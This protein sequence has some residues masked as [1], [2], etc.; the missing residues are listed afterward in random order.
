MAAGH[1]RRSPPEDV[2]PPAVRAEGRQQGAL[3]TDGLLRRVARGD[4]AAFARVCDEVSGAV[5]GLV[6]L[7]VAD[8]A[9]AEQVASDV[10]IEVWRSAPRFDPAENS[11]LSWIMTMARRRAISQAAAS[12]P[13]AGSEPGAA[14]GAAERAAGSL[15]AHRG[16]AVLPAQQ[17]TAVSLAC[18]GYTGRQVAELAGVPAA[19]AAVWLRDG[20]LGLSSCPDYPAAN[21]TENR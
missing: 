19:T 14:A 3:S 13:P 6:S 18:C 7:I 11:G 5:Y 10:L 9:Q 1:E 15:L 16:L 20:L 8:P 21:E 12:G 17:R 4:A 2:A